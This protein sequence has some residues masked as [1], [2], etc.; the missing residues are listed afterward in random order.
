MWPQRTRDQS[1]PS[2]EQDQHDHGIEQTR[3]LKVDVHVGDDARENEQRACNGKEP[4]DD[5][6]AIPEKNRYAD[7]HGQQ[8]DAETAAAPETPVRPNHGDL[9]GDEKASDA[10]HGEAK[11]KLAQPAGGSADIAD[12]TVVH[13]RKDSTLRSAG[14]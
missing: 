11:Q 8:R 9:V 13:A 12:L 1:Q 5:A 4:S 14:K 10:G 6:L 3:G 2:Y 7:Q